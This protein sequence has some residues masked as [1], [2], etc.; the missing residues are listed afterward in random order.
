MIKENRKLAGRSADAV[1]QRGETERG[2]VERIE[3]L[4]EQLQVRE[5]EE[6]RLKES[7]GEVM[8]RTPGEELDQA[9]ADEEEG[10]GRC[11]KDGAEDEKDGQDA[12]MQTQANA[13]ASAERPT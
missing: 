9:V 5:A 11:D 1:E 10:E 6:Q 4:N 12:E 7:S 13:C 2:C 3:E 8:E